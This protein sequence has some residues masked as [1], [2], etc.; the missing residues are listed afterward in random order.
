MD[1]AL[2]NFRAVKDTQLYMFAQTHRV[3]NTVN[4]P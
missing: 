4:E 3:Y 1:G 2:R